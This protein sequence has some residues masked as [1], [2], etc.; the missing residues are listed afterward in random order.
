MTLPLW[1]FIFL[2]FSN[3]FHSNEKNNI[4]VMTASNASKSLI[5]QAVYSDA[6]N[7]LESKTV[8]VKANTF[9]L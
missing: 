7:M 4:F 6:F 3:I 5:W 8:S 1:H 9:I 2:F